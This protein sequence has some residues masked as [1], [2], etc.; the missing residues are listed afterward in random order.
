[1]PCCPHGRGCQ[2]LGETDQPLRAV[3]VEQG[4]VRAGSYVAWWAVIMG[5]W[6]TDLLLDKE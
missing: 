5:C 2:R 1:V 4:F 6:T 3:G